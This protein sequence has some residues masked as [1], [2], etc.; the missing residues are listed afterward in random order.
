[1]KQAQSDADE[2]IA[3]YRLEQQ[4]AFDKAT[5]ASGKSIPQTHYFV[6]SLRRATH[7]CETSLYH[8]PKIKADLEE[9]PQPNSRQKPTKMFRQCRVN[10]LRT[11][12]RL[13]MSFCRNAVRL[14]WRYQL[15][16]FVQ[17][18]NCLATKL[19][20]IRREGF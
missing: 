1:M 18:K 15:P 4:D 13:W 9:T 2:L 6:M 10:S 19:G 7:A 8:V 5:N 12:K 20:G 11:H 14:V 17:H 16:G 3:A